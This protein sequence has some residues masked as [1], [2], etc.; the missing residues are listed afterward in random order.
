MLALLVVLACCAYFGL[1]VVDSRDSQDWKP[2]DGPSRRYR[3][4]GR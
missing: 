4:D 2:F 1:G 3:E